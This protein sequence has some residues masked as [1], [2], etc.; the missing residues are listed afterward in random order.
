MRFPIASE[1]VVAVLLG[2]RLVT[3]KQVTRSSAKAFQYP[4]AWVWRWFA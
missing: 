1:G 4:G 3:R 2:E